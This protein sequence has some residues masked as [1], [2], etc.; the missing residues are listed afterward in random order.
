MSVCHLTIKNEWESGQMANAL[1]PGFRFCFKFLA[2]L[3]LHRASG[4]SLVVV[5][6]FSLQWLLLCGAQAL[7]HSG[8]RSCSMW[9]Q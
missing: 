8:F 9:P 6:R 3:G 7:G 5:C 2:V 1:D 4:F